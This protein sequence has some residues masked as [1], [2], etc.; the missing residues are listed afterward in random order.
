MS[1]FKLNQ[2]MLLL[3]SA[4]VNREIFV[5]KN[6]R[7]E[8]FRNFVIQ[9]NARAHVSCAFIRVAAE[10]VSLKVLPYL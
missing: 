3:L 4:T 10:W 8:I 7:D 1:F 6:I 5:L 9:N 2:M